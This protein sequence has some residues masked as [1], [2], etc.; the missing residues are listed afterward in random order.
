MR[1]H[2]N[3]QLLKATTTTEGTREVQLEKGEGTFTD[4][5]LRHDLD[6]LIRGHHDE[7]E[8]DDNTDII[9]M[10]KQFNDFHPR[11]F[12]VLRF[13]NSFLLFFTAKSN[14]REYIEPQL[15]RLRSRIC[16]PSWLKA[17][18]T[19]FQQIDYKRSQ[20]LTMAEGYMDR[21]H[22]QEYRKLLEKVHIIPS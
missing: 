6:E 9:D 13:N 11:A 2:G 17:F 18:V 12:G 14:V 7:L 4:A 10:Q 3:D 8:D 20:I 16:C 15:R 5:K 19:D 22:L 1:W 21:S